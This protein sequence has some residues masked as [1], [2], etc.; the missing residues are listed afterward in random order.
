[1]RNKFAR[2]V[3]K[4]NGILFQ[5][6]SQFWNL[7]NPKEENELIRRSWTVPAQVVLSV[8]IGHPSNIRLE[9]R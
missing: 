3:G 6:C 1:M 8:P 2:G 4:R 7:E 9:I 5:L